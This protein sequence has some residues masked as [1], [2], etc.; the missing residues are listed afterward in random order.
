[1]TNE[2][3][4]TPSPYRDMTAKWATDRR[5]AFEERAG[6]MMDGGMSQEDAEREA[7]RIVMGLT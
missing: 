1:M 6:I 2:F 3:T 5:E 7:Y 4:L